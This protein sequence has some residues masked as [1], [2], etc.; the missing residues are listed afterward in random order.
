MSAR[1]L[2]KI[3]VLVANMGVWKGEELISKEWIR[4]STIPRHTFSQ[5]QYRWPMDSYGYLWHLDTEKGN[6][7]GSGYGGQYVMIDTT[8]RLALVQRHNTGNSWLSQA[9]YLRK[10]TQSSQADLMQIWYGLTRNLPNLAK[11]K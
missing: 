7:W 2:A 3:G 4:R 6:I 11:S 8:N 5:D 1:D 10:S 9:L